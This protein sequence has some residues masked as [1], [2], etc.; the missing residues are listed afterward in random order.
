M[1][2]ISG[3]IIMSYLLIGV[4]ICSWFIIKKT[5]EGKFK[6]ITF[7]AVIIWPLGAIDLYEMVLPKYRRVIRKIK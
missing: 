1:L 4:L 6:P 2:Q 3:I 5:I 7:L